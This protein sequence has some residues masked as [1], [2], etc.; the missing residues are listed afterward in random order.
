MMYKVEF[1][2][3]KFDWG[4]QASTK[5]DRL[6]DD[7]LIIL[8]DFMEGFYGDDEPDADDIDDLVIFDLHCIRNSCQSVCGYDT[9]FLF[10]DELFE[11]YV[12]K[13]AD[14]FELGYAEIVF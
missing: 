5:I 2:A 8:D 4:F 3:A 11:D 6:N 7:E 13:H 12:T 9:V 10:G 14:D 1:E